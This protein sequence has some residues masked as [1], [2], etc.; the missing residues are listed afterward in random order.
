MKITKKELNKMI[1]EAVKQRLNEGLVDKVYDALM[2]VPEYKKL[3]ADRQG[4][5][6]VVVKKMIQ[7]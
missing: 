2:K 6:S 1:E 5:I 4:E 7:E 3:S